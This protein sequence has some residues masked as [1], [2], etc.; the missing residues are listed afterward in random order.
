MMI[1]EFYSRL[2]GCASFSWSSVHA[3]NLRQAFTPQLQ[4]I[5]RQS[6]LRPD[7]YLGSLPLHRVPEICLAFSFYEEKSK[8]INLYDWYVQFMDSSAPRKETSDETQ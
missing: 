6:L 8:R 1:L 4:T 7:I 2:V 5:L 3:H